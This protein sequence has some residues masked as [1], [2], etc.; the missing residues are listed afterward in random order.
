MQH[1]E[2]EEEWQAR[3]GCKVLEQTRQEIYMDLRF[4]GIALSALTL[5]PQP[6][7][8]AIATDG[9]LLYF[10]PE[11]VIRVFRDNPRF[12]DRAYLHTVLHCL[13]SHLW[14]GGKRDKN[15]W[16][17]ACDIAVEYTID[18]MDKPCTRR[19]LSFMRRNMYERLGQEKSV[20]SAAVIYRVLEEFSAGEQAQLVAEFYTDDHCYW[21]K[22]E[23]G[24]AM[25]QAALAS[26][27]KWEKIARQTRMEQERQGSIDGEGERLLEAGFR[28]GKKKRSYGEF[29]RKFS[30]LREEAGLDPEEFDLNSYSYGLRLYGNMPLVEPVETREVRKIR[31]FVIVVDTSDSTRGELVEQFLR[32]T[33]SIISQQNRFFGDAR[34]HIMQCD[35]QVRRD[36]VVT[37]VSDLERLMSHF[38]VTGGGGTDFRP[39]F[40]YVQELLEQGAFRNLC[41]LLYFTDGKGIYPKKK[42]DY[43]CAF[44]FLEDYEEEAVPP[45]AMRFRME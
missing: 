16:D 12:L 39:V 28:A 1:I 17:L 42:P 37:G 44:L 2:T 21:P 40:A 11:Q 9:S 32:E 30:I 36:D 43:K 31:E 13:F 15:Q 3:M 27:E 19:I 24:K 38:T 34:I 5:N 18:T 22:Q 45:W 26:R 4:F 29:L 10:A 14:I 8:K 20:I 7:L 41:G 35:D 6:A 25:P 33:V 23:D